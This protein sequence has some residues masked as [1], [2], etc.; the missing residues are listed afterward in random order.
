GSRALPPTVDQAPLAS[1]PQDDGAV[2]ARPD[3]HPPDVRMGPQPVEQLG[4]AVVE[5]L[6]GE[7][8]RRL[9]EIDEP[10]VAGAQDDGLPVR[11][12]VLGALLALPAAR[13]ADG[14]VDH[15]ALLVAVRDAG[16]VGL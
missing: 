13:L 11:D 8:P 10:E 16:H 9:H 7:P 5:L 3:H 1:R 12:V 14:L 4:M 15:R 6:P 2:V